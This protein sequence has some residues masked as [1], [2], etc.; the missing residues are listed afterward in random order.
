MNSTLLSVFI[1]TFLFVSATPGMC[2]TLSL[3][4]GMQIGVS[5]TLWMM[6]GELLGVGLV[7]LAA[8][9]GVATLL[10]AFPSVF[11]ILKVGGAVFLG[12]LGIQLWR[13]R[14][15]LALKLDSELI[16]PSR[17]NLVMQGFVTAVANPKGWAFFI[18]L[19]P[20]FIDSNQP[21]LP[22][23]VTLISLILMIEWICLMLYATGG[24]SLGRFLQQASN[25]RLA[26][27]I[28]GTLMIGV[29]LWLLLE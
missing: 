5:R 12:Y 3:T 13:S 1:P 16:L 19:L 20:P 24:R 25:V 8:G 7:A 15:S 23:V 18:A 11:L 2:M 22:Q 28:S 9:V 4:L 29:G 6:W 10:L 14:G 21:V 17:R 27:R 26:N